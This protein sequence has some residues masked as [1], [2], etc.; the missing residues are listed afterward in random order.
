MYEHGGWYKVVGTNALT[1]CKK[2]VYL[3][4]AEVLDKNI[5]LQFHRHH[6][7]FRKDFQMLLTVKED[8]IQPQQ[9]ALDQI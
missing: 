8:E 1:K 5:I 6:S 3:H 9:H 2:K 7:Y 4:Y